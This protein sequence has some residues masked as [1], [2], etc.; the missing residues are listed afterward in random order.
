MKSVQ[1]ASEDFLVKLA[2]AAKD[3]VKEGYYRIPEPVRLDRRNFAGALKVDRRIPIIAEVKFQSPSEGKIAEPRGVADIARAYEKGGASAI[4]VLTEPDSFAGK[5]EYLSA[6]KRSVGLPVLMKDV[7]VDRSQV[8]AGDRAGADA[9][10][11]I[12][13]VFDRGLSQESMEGL[14]EIAH[15]RGM[16]VVAE[17]HD[18]DELELAVEGDADFV[19]INNRDLGSL[20]V[21]LETSRRLLR[22]RSGKKPVICESGISTRGEID[23]LR[24]LGADGFLVGSALMRSDDPVAMLNELTRLDR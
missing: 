24:S 13:G 14:T 23:S 11:L 5:L 7:V 3:R 4:S 18:E 6:V 9:I 20:S 19:G 15:R 2:D 21:S 10:L 8:E 16:G 12:V 17:V 22:R 1:R